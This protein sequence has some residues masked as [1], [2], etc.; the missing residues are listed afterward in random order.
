MLRLLP[1]LLSTERGREEKNNKR[2]STPPLASY[3]SGLLAVIT[4]IFYVCLQKCLWKYVHCKHPRSQ[5][6]C[7]Y[8]VRS[9]AQSKGCAP[10]LHRT[11]LHCSPPKPE[12]PWAKSRAN[13]AWANRFNFLTSICT[14]ANHYIG[15][16][17]ELNKSLESLFFLWNER[18]YLKT[19][20]NIQTEPVPLQLL[21][22]KRIGLF[23]K[24]NQ[25]KLA[26]VLLCEWSTKPLL[27]EFGFKKK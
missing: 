22:F 5:S 27:I 12:M 10:A 25:R 21:L 17:R 4:I 11:K 18:I 14:Y 26:L 7:S 19:Q 3:C 20:L 13:T 2:K 1:L 8:L 23:R 15:P 6:G 16:R 24:Q 9:S